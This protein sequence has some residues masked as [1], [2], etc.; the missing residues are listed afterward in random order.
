MAQKN[1]LAVYLIGAGLVVIGVSFFI[2]KKIVESSASGPL[3]ATTE[4]A[5]GR[6]FLIKKYK[7]QKIQL[8]DPVDVFSLDTVETDKDSELV[9]SFPSAYRIRLLPETSVVFEVTKSAT[10]LI[11]RR[12]DVKIENFGREDSVWIT[13]QGQKLSA[14]AYELKKNVIESP[15]EATTPPLNVR[16]EGL[17]PEEIQNTLANSRGPFYKC[18]T[19]LLQKTPGV[20][21]QASM[22]FTILNSG[23]IS[24]PQV[25]HSSLSDERFKACLIEALSRI[26]FKSFVGEPISTVFPLK[27]E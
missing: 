6:V 23:K 18:Y 24:A 26:E 27:F 12:G 13:S 20:V 11:L 14:T 21:G 22:T 4:E 25:S 7:T 9:V 15:P 1:N 19:Q 16:N 3:A 2:S 10:H 5:S 8:K 17:T